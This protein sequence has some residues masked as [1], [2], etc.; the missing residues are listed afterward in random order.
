LQQSVAMTETPKGRRIRP[1]GVGDAIFASLTRASGL[2]VLLLLG[3]IILE[4]FM[5]GLPAF[6]RFGMPFLW[7][8]EWD[9]VREVFGAA[10]PIYGTIVT[11]ILALIL[12]V[13]L[14]FGIA[15]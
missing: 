1:S 9:P 14:S 11:S 12:A 2:F 15:F 8:A 7:S 3:A 10:V 4:L 6:R 13:P 5:G